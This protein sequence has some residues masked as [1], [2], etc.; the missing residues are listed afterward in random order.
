VLVRGPEL[1][2]TADWHGRT[3]A[4]TGD[5]SAPADLEVWAPDAR[6]VSWNGKDVGTRA[7][8]TG[9]LLVKKQLAG[10]KAVTLP[11]LSQA[12]WRTA[13]ESPESAPSFDDSTWATADKTSTNSTTP[14][15]AG[16]PVLTA[17][18]YGFHQG[19]VWYRGRYTGSTTGSTLNLRYGGGGAGMLQAWLDGV[20][21]GQNVLAS[22]LSS[23]PTTGTATFTIPASLRT[24][25]P[26]ELSVMVRDDG[27][28]E[29]G[30]VNDAQKEGRGLISVGFTDGTSPVAT[31]VGWKIQGDL[32][33]E[34]L[35]DPARGVEN[36]GGLYGE[37]NGWNLPGYPDGSWSRASVPA[38]TAAPGTQWY[39]TSFRLH[40]PKTDDASLGVTIGDP[41]TPHSSADYRALIYVN[42]WNVGQY[43]ANVGPQ[44]T[45]VVPNGILDPHGK[46]TLAIAVTSDGGTGNGLENVALTNLGTVAGGVPVAMDKAPSWKASVYGKAPVPD[47][48]TVDGVSTDAGNPAR[49][50]DTIHVTGTVTNRGRHAATGLHATLD[51]PAGWTVTGGGVPATL[52]PGASAGTQWTV[53]VPADAATGDYQL[54]DETG[55]TQDKTAGSTGATATVT[56]RSTGDQYVSDLPFVSSTNGYG[57]VER[58]TNV[59]G[60]GAGDGGT[61]TIR[62]ATYAKG[63]G[64]NSV[65]QVVIDVGGACTSF[66]SDVGVDDS[67]GGKG[68]VTFTVLA[69]GRQVA[70]TGTM[71]GTSPVQHLS[72]DITGAQTLTLQVGDGGDGNGH[73]NADWAGAEVHC[74]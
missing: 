33:G 6:Q 72:A 74:G 71:T 19:D 25:G 14:P 34:N 26:H 15:P 3:L 50:G 30:G 52:A 49:P 41:S 9:S 61:I 59:G 8:A 51:A 64:T 27:H 17:D 24:A 35:V 58:D 4:L 10:P 65:S 20:Y 48:V 28:N 54:A 29:D 53:T 60:S 63:L 18:D 69:D 44:H 11:D 46:N 66:T 55:Y 5:T 12:T 40:V 42:G 21:L 13:A 43:I 56:V 31:A 70:S 38:A 73:D 68:S 32:G 36:A 57:P 45:F 22:N 39:R 23:P 1:V 47:R 2:R 7:T 37:R 16:Q 67:A 62:G